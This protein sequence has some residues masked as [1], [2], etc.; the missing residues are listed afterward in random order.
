MADP[1]S[2]GSD[3]FFIQNRSIDKVHRDAGA[4]MD[5]F[6]QHLHLHCPAYFDRD[7]VR[8]FID[9]NRKI[10]ILFIQQTARIRKSQHI[11]PGFRLHLVYHARRGKGGDAAF[12]KAK[13]FPCL[14]GCQTGQYRQIPG[15][16]F[17][18]LY[19]AF[20]GIDAD[21][22]DLLIAANILTCRQRA[23]RDLDMRQTCTVS[24]GRNLIDAGTKVSGI[25]DRIEQL[26]QQI[27]NTVDAVILQG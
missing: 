1:V 24:G 20:S 21:L 16:Y 2:C 19:I 23:A 12:F 4:L 8:L 18:H 25:G 14:K 3:R 6:L 9:I 22:L 10:R 27:E 7:P 26:I 17:R 13:A 11:C 5:L 15:R